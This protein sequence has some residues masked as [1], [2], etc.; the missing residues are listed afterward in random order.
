M[1][2][3][4]TEEHMTFRGK[5]IDAMATYADVEDMISIGAYVDGTDPKIEW[6]SG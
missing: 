4:V 5:L 2:D 1:R 3:V 6:P